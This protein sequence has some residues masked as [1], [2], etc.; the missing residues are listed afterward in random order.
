MLSTV[1][2]VAMGLVP[3]LWRRGR[4]I[5]PFSDGKKVLWNLEACLGDID[6]TIEETNLVEF[7]RDLG[8]LYPK[9]RKYGLI[10][11]INDPTLFQGVWY[12]SLVSG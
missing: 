3:L 6:R 4:M 8:A 7:Q 12:E 11:M 9:L 2:D 10:L 5:L 1:L